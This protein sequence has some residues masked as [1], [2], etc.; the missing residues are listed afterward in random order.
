[1]ILTFV[2]YIFVHQNDNKVVAPTT[3]PVSTPPE[4]IPTTTP[5]TTP[6]TTGTG[7]KDGTY[8]GSTE[9]AFYGFIQ[10][11]AVIQQGKITDVKFLQFPNDRSTSIE[12]NT[13]AMPLLKQE[14]IRA[15]SSN[16]SIVS[17]ATDSSMAFVQS[18]KT[19]LTQAQQSAV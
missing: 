2:A 3:T 19:A 14:A 18:L 8:T 17:G 5:V 1:M 10:V 16:V 12:I 7:L 13:Q 15:Q 6:V 9:D 4:S 11:Q